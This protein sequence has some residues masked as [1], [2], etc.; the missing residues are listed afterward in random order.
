MSA[1]LYITLVFLLSCASPHQAIS[2]RVDSLLT[3]AINDPAETFGEN[4]V[5][6]DMENFEMPDYGDYRHYYEQAVAFDYGF[7]R[8]RP[9][10]LSNRYNLFFLEDVAMRDPFFD[11]PLWSATTGLHSAMNAN[12]YSR[13]SLLRS[14]EYYTTYSDAPY[15]RVG[16]SFSNR[17][18]TH[19]ATAY[20]NTGRLKGGWSAAAAGAFRGGRSLNIDGVWANSWTGALNV[21]KRFGDKHF[22]H[23]SVLYSP[24][25]RAYAGASTEEAFGLVGNKLYNPSWGYQG[26]VG[27]EFERSSRIRQTQIPIGVLKYAYMID[28]RTR[29]RVVVS[30][31]YGRLSNAT[32]NWQDAP[33]PYPDY[34]RNM[35]SFQTD[36]TARKRLEE[37]WATDPAVSQINFSE[38]YDLNRKASS[39]AHYIM[40]NRVR[41]LAQVA[42]TVGVDYYWP[43]GAVTVEAQFSMASERNYKTVRDLMG[44]RYW[45]DVDHFLESDDDLR[46]LTQV[47]MAEPNR[48]VEVGD[49]FGYNYRLQYL[50]GRVE[51]RLV[52]R[53][54]RSVKL[55]ATVEAGVSAVSRYGYWEKENFAGAASLG[56][57]E[58]A[59]RAEGRVNLE[60]IYSLGGRWQVVGQFTASSLAPTARDQFISPQYRNAFVEKPTNEMLLGGHIRAEYTGAKF[61]TRA[62]VFYAQMREGTRLHHLY[63]DISRTYVDFV[64]RHIATEH[65]GFEASVEVLLTRDLWIKGMFSLPIARY[66][67]NPEATSYRQ[68]TGEEL[69]QQTVYFDN[70]RVASVP[71]FLASAALSYEP[72]GWTV[73]LTANG[74]GNSYV[75]P[76]PTRYTEA[77]TR[78][79]AS[80]DM[81]TQE[82]MSAGVTLNLFGGK[83]F[84]FGGGQRLNIY[85]GVNNLL[86]SVDIATSGYQSYR[87]S[88][89]VM[90][91]YTPH[92]TRYNYALGINGFVS[93]SFVF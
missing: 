73:A 28:P 18:Y 77:A 40:E 22:L 13:G 92:A 58:T 48:Q 6:P 79:A 71:S 57:S 78:K 17:T 53:V 90:G 27:K 37:S 87:L 19:T 44:A 67:G 11:T 82:V 10:G 16:Y 89:N 14:D 52:Q 8:M 51:G 15:G 29:L 38:L 34:Y 12:T 24:T 81:I 32:L 74:F 31:A 84:Y 25:E 21:A 66:I 91:R 26:G 42:A 76:S 85:A 59:A 41:D 4:G 88:R 62:T 9:R 65:L 7:L 47:N 68:T 60:A 80:A 56:R 50:R 33:N 5:A 75:T 36:P 35:P 86:N 54:G 72:R 2:Q 63:D 3:Q 83:T 20:Y 69:K 45:L 46:E 49:V 1:R 70:L 39:S 61:R 64:M 43:S 55:L 23:L 30:G 93:V